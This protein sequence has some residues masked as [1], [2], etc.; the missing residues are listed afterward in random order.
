M[1]LHL[2][3]GTNGC[4]IKRNFEVL[5]CTCVFYKAVHVPTPKTYT[6][7][8]ESQGR[9]H[10]LLFSDHMPHVGSAK[11]MLA[12]WYQAQAQAAP[13]GAHMQVAGIQ[14]GIKTCQQAM[15]EGRQARFPFCTVPLSDIRWHQCCSK[16]CFLPRGA[17]FCPGGRPW[18]H[19]ATQPQGA[20]MEENCRGASPQNLASYLLPVSRHVLRSN[21]RPEA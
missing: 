14:F 20:F 19:A 1:R 6:N 10:A 21:E 4:C 17:A 5:Q 12:H 8:A 16:G 2:C 18:G 13:A 11:C 3:L 15:S 7:D 9:K